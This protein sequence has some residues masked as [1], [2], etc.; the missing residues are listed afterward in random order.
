[1][2]KR[3]KET[4]PNHSFLA[5]DVVM[6]YLIVNGDDFGASPAINLGIRDAHRSGILTSASLLVNAEMSEQAAA[7]ARATPNLSVGLHADLRAELEEQVLV[8]QRL[9][10]SLSS[11]FSRFEELMDR[12][13]THLDS[14]HNSHLNLRALP[15]F[16]ELARKHG[17]PLRGH[18]SVRYF[19]KFY[20]QWGGQTH[21]EQ[22]SVEKLAAMIERE[23]G[24]GV[25]ELSCHPGH[26]DANHSSTYR[27][28]REAELRTLC[29]PRIRD[30]LQ[31][32]A[33]RLISYHDF[34]K[35][36]MNTPS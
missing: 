23:I 16:L 25:T 33:I 21:L 22:I 27:I 1:M 20:G 6:K 12:T 17:L 3:L 11:Q 2:V 29:D 35:L 34:A 4:R 9:R 36:S 5:A 24:D 15:H 28:E 26:V 8:S 13:P 7:L 31:R 19:S 14:H 10:E 18:S 30:V 32:Q